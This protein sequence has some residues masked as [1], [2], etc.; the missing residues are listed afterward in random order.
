[1]RRNWIQFILELIDS[2]PLR[3]VLSYLGYKI[4][5]SCEWG[6]FD[7]LYSVEDVMSCRPCHPDMSVA[8][9]WSALKIVAIGTP[10]F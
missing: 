3:L 2:P 6:S 9:P 5:Y 7:Y 4:V 10:S 1:M 8:P